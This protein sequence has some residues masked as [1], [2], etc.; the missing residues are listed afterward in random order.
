MTNTTKDTKR[1][2]MGFWL[3]LTGVIL[4]ALGWFFSILVVHADQA[5][6]ARWGTTLSD[7]MRLGKY[8]FAVI[9]GVCMIA[10]AFHWT[11]SNVLERSRRDAAEA[12]HGS[13][14]GASE[15]VRLLRAIS[16]RLVLSDDVKRIIYRENNRDAFRKAI[17]ED[18]AKRDFDAAL[19]IVDQMTSVYGYHQEA[20]QFRTRIQEVQAEELNREVTEAVA[21]LE[22][23]IEAEQWERA[24][25]E[26]ASIQRRFPNSARVSNL[27][28]HV[29]QAKQRV[30]VRME[31]DFLDAAGRDDVEQA[32][33]LLKK[34]DVYLT[35]KEAEPFRETARG[36]IGKK[37][38][39]LGLQ[40][41]LAVADK[42]WSNA[43]NVG[44]EIIR[45][46]PNSQM[47]NE[48][49]E[50]LDVLRE[51][52]AGERAARASETV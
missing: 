26:A 52:A 11:L 6:W 39:N 32:M 31:R 12:M 40:F 25:A 27:V 41:K 2:P 38:Q 13:D 37:R 33:E 43:L 15:M 46:C 16:D 30:K 10:G 47:A 4:G 51:R 5:G 42:E 1:L 9:G 50:M 28:E 17:E 21:G 22:R 3:I 19:K 45:E 14:D 44:E 49:R 8:A 48:V 24:M 7:L 35:E 34:L 29:K 36:V 20:E 23:Y 18:I